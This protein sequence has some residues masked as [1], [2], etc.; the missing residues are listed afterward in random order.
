MDNIFISILVLR[1][2]R[3][4]RFGIG[5]QWEHFKSSV[6]FHRLNKYLLK[7]VKCGRKE[8]ENMGRE[9][10]RGSGERCGSAPFSTLEKL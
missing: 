2:L 1:K 7:R 8:M 10:M 9:G 3:L 4:N 5:I 6:E